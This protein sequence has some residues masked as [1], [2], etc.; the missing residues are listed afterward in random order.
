MRQAVFVRENEKKWGGYESDLK[1]I[2]SV[3]ADKLSKMYVELTE[4]LAFCRAKFPTTRLYRYLNEMTLKVHNRIYRNKPEERSRIIT[5]WTHELPKTLRS[6][7]INIIYSFLLLLVGAGIGWLSGAND[8]D[9][10]RL[11]LGDGYV[12]MTLTNID[13]GDPMAVY[14]SQG[15]SDMFFGITINNIRVSFLAFAFGL[16]TSLGTGYILFTNGIMLGVFHQLFH[17]RGLFDET[18]L[19]IWIHGT[20]EISAIIIAGAAGITL[21]NGFLFPKNYP[22]MYAFRTTA[23][24]GLKIVLSLV[25]FFIAAGFIEGFITRYT[26]WSLWAKLSIVGISASIVLYY[27]FILPNHNKNVIKAN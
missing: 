27:L 17:S 8:H 26:H 5:F 6:H 20:L 22:R 14:K 18:V 19:T 16:F 4:D 12:D 2:S 15:R 24:D 13:K 23:K 7:R 21:G 11:I 25:P 3:S 9:F 10:A 1:N